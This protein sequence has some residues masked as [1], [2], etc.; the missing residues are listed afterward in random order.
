MFV[1]ASAIIAILCEEPSGPALPKA[2]DAKKT[3]KVASVLAVWEAAVGLRRKK[4]LS[5]A[6]AEGLVRDFLE[7]ARVEMIGIAA[8]E[9]S[10]AVRA[11]DRYGRHRYPDAERNKALNMADCF[12]YAC[13]KARR[14]PILHND[15]GLALTDARSAL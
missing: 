12:H 4:Q 10:L 6:D 15:V 3:S 2:L 8:D 14:A 7:A 1:D 9:L 11:Y 13:A 5:T